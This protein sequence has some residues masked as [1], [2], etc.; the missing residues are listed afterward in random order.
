MG[1]DR[2]VATIVVATIRWTNS[3]LPLW[4]S[5]VLRHVQRITKGRDLLKFCTSIAIQ[6]Q[7]ARMETNESMVGIERGKC[8]RNDIKMPAI[9]TSERGL[10]RTAH[11]ISTPRESEI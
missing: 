7:E 1:V 8:V 10:Q 5:F 6:M 9:P 11:E 2:G 4:T 3:R